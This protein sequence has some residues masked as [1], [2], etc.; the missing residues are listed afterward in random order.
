MMLALIFN[1]RRFVCHL[2]YC[3]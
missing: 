3:N 2:F 1:Y